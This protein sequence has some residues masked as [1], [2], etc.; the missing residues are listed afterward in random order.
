M[1]HGKGILSSEAQA[2]GFILGKFEVKDIK[3]I[4]NDTGT[5]KSR[6]THTHRTGTYLREGVPFFVYTGLGDR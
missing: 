2:S 1:V 3:L 6:D 5:D 4:S